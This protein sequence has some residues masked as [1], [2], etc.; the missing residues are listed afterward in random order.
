METEIT[1]AFH[2]VD[3]VAAFKTEDSRIHSLSWVWIRVFRRGWLVVAGVFAHYRSGA[4]EG[5]DCSQLLMV[6]ASAVSVRLAP[7]YHMA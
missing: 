6:V 5:G 4:F 1:A 2:I 3:E 7:L